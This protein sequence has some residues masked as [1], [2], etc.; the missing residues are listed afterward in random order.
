MGLTHLIH[1]CYIC[2]RINLGIVIMH[3]QR[4]N[5]E[6]IICTCMHAYKLVPY[7]LTVVSNMLMLS[8]SK[9]NSC[10]L[11]S[12]FPTSS[13]L[14]LRP[15]A[16][17]PLDD[18]TRCLKASL[19]H[20]DDFCKALARPRRAGTTSMYTRASVGRGVIPQGQVQIHTHSL[21]H[22]HADTPGSLWVAICR[23]CCENSLNTLNSVCMICTNKIN[24]NSPIQYIYNKVSSV[25]G[26]FAADLGYRR[27][28]GWREWYQPCSKIV[29]PPIHLEY[30]EIHVRIKII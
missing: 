4:T 12:H 15:P 2:R 27:E 7:H 18:S 19:R 22:T 25:N 13:A 3:T 30:R 24:G 9:S 6:G 21:T 28:R 5:S 26:P 8:A 17:P 1:V 16:T 23:N 20:A 29:Q 14:W 11:L 10:P